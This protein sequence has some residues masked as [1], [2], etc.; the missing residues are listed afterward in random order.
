MYW[1]DSTQVGHYKTNVLVR[2]YTSRSLHTENDD[3]DDDDNVQA[4][5]HLCFLLTTA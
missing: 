4:I 1:L 3:D 2:F 5:A